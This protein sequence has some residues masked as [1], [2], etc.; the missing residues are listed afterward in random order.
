MTWATN[1]KVAYEDHAIRVLEFRASNDNK[2]TLFVPPQAGHESWIADFKQGQSLVECALI[3]SKGGVYS[4]DWKG[5]T[6]FRALEN[7][8]T[9]QDQLITAIDVT[10]SDRIHV[11]GL[12]QG[13]WVTALASTNRPDKFNEITLAG[14]PIDTSFECIIS[15]AGKVPLFIYQSVVM[16][17]GGIMSGKLMLDAW[18][19]P[20][21]ETHRKAELLPENDHF[22]SWYNKTQNLSGAWYLWAIDNIFINNRLPSMLN[23]SCKV[24]TVAGLKDDITPPDQTRAV[25][26][27]CDQLT[28]DYEINKGHL[29]VFMSREAVK[30]GGVWAVIFGGN[31]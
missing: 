10:N 25:Q 30:P 15:P 7:V 4:I 6:V 3:N 9:L 22:Y 19:K 5:S 8:T 29:G 12:C 1:Y 28:T 26:T 2:T 24:N 20:N 14:T 11:V 21:A 27:N 31:Q 16:M 18:K 23:I 13:G 17:C